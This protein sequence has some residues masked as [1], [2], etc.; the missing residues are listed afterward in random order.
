MP[1]PPLHSEHPVHRI[2]K[3]RSLFGPLLSLTLVLAG[4]SYIPH[5]LGYTGG[6]PS[7]ARVVAD[8]EG[9]DSNPTL[10]VI[11]TSQNAE[12]VA[13]YHI[14]NLGYDY[15]DFANM[16]YSNGTVHLDLVNAS[17]KKVGDMTI[18]AKRGI[19]ARNP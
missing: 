15:Q 16:K 14:K 10:K 8:Y 2:M 18:D 6:E 11:F 5:P 4:C 7:Y 1:R 3:V 13:R 17:N 19:I 12:P 9:R